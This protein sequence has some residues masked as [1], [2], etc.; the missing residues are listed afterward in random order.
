MRA[1]S[2]RILAQLGVSQPGE[3]RAALANKVRLRLLKEWKQQ[4][5]KRTPFALLDDPPAELV[6]VKRP[7]RPKAKIVKAAEAPAS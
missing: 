3:A 7:R 5:L 4:E 2:R 6:A 1:P